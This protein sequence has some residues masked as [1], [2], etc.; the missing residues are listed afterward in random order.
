MRTVPSVRLDLVSQS[1]IHLPEPGYL[2]PGESWH[3]SP[4]PEDCQS[5]GAALRNRTG[6]YHKTCEL[7]CPAPAG[8]LPRLLAVPLTESADAVK[9]GIG[10][11]HWLPR[12]TRRGGHALQSLPGWAILDAMQE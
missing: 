2:S 9:S 4:G 8:Q 12:Q 11:L 6:L 7:S 10:A 1:D 3:L 5:G